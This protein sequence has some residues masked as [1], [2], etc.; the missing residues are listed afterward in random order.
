MTFFCCINRVVV[1]IRALLPAYRLALS[2]CGLGISLQMG[3]PAPVRAAEIRPGLR[4]TVAGTVTTVFSRSR[5]GC[6]PVDIPDAPARAIR[7][8][9]GSVQLYAAHLYNRRFVGP[10][11]LT[12]SNDCRIVFKGNERDDPAAFDDRAWIA[13][14]YTPDGRTIFAA[15]HNEFQGQRR[16]ALCPS[17]Q[18]MDCWYNAITAA[19]SRDGGMGFSRLAPG[20]DL[21]A[22]L[23]YRYDEVTG[24]H[25]GYFNPSNMVTDKGMLLMMVFATEA[26]AQRPGNCLLRTDR[27]S[28]PA[29]WRAWDGK[30]FGASF[31]DPYVAAATKDVHVC[32]PV[33][34][35]QLRW[36]VTSL[37]RHAPSGLF[38]ALMMNGAHDGG[39]F[40]ATSLNLIDWSS[41]IKLMDGLGEG[42]YRCGD[43]GPI[44]YP[45]LLDTNSSD[46]NFMTVGD[47]AELF[48]TR[49]NVSG[50]KTSMD[51]DLIRIPI[52][53]SFDRY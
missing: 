14:L 34:G 46:R 35:G 20:S 38:I 29:A 50:C 37:V 39:V 16:P 6:D 36:P 53:I 52:A 13:S 51:R 33:G 22:A 24:H 12:L 1:V 40:F 4:L 5:N 3:I 18:Y 43:A 32:A 11:L 7:L 48:L 17:G 27:I 19:V 8:A 26:K 31:I 15:I 21:I 2:V 45:S 44:A 47:S 10:N 42:T 9:S 23:P 49:F 30:G 28:D 41:P 25:V